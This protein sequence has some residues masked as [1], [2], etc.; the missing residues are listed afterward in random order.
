MNWQY[1]IFHTI[2]GLGLMIFG[3]T[4]MSESLQNLAGEKL[5]AILW[6]VS[7][8]RVLAALT[9][10]GVTAVIQ[11]SSATTVM[12]VG[13]VNAGLMS[14]VQAVGVALGAHVGTT[15]TAQLMAF[16]I[17]GL[18]LPAI[19]LGC[20]M[21]LF[22]RSRLVRELGGFLLGFGLLFYGMELIKGG[23]APLKDQGLIAGFFTRFQ[24]DSFGGI[25]LGVLVG[26]GCTM[27]IQSS[28]VT[29]G[30]TMALAA[31]GLLTLPG[32]MA[33]VLGDNIGT[34][35]TAELAALK[36]DFAARRM[37][38]TNSISNIIGATYMVLLFPFYLEFVQ[39][40]TQTFGHL[41][42]PEELVNG[43]KPNISRYVANAHTIFNLINVVVMLSLLPI[44]V[45]VG[46]AL[47]PKGRETRRES[48]TAPLYLDEGALKTPA[49]ALSQS[50]RELVRMADISLQMAAEVFPVLASRRHRDM[51]E[52]V[53]KEEALDALQRALHHYLVQLYN[54]KNSP[55][56]RTNITDQMTVATYLE[57]LGDIVNNIAELISHGLD[58]NI[59]LSEAALDEY[60]TIADTALKFH[61]L[62]VQAMKDNRADIL[63]P[64]E[65]LEN[66]LD[67]M[68][69]TMRLNHLD[70]L[71]SGECAV[72]QG[73]V[74][75]DLLNHFERLGDYLLKVAR[76]WVRL[77][78]GGA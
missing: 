59:Q 16:N 67:Q 55:D 23:V 76:A 74:F 72:D 9:G 78:G 22:G 56:E 5:K 61:D 73:L 64:A 14:T 12:L 26:A 48:L 57:R 7:H 70:R 10:M 49:V 11:S 77:S 15:M 66:R 47:T 68:R 53:I 37:A 8:N 6:A 71:Q 36:T 4:I 58:H 19:G 33:L 69:D 21:R 62:V 46:Q 24:A 30:L 51:E 3:M 20:F 63:D 25:I 13:F 44:L 28:S 40:F 52:H 42:P 50:R 2:G 17:A 32:A 29:V 18:A 45:K 1:V 35:I 27:I 54:D 75:T 41:G 60:R 31:Q 34:T 43:V 65:E 38:R 39:W